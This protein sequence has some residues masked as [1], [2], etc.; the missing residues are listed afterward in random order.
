MQ[1]VRSVHPPLPADTIVRVSLLLE[2]GHEHT[3]W[4]PAR[5]PALAALLT[6]F[7][8]S[9]NGTTREGLVEITIDGG[10]RS[11]CFDRASLVAVITEPP[12]AMNSVT[13]P[14]EPPPLR[15]VP[16][17]PPR[18]VPESVTQARPLRLQNFLRSEEH[19]GLIRYA[20]AR[21]QDFVST[22]V[23]TDH[24]GY[25]ASSV[26]YEFP[27]FEKLLRAK[28]MAALPE[29]FN[30]FKL[31]SFLPSAIEAQLTAHND[32]HFYHVH[33]D[34]GSPATANRALSYVYYFNRQP[35]GFAGG[36]LRLYDTRVENNFYVRA[37]SFT[38]FEPIDNSIIFFLPYFM[39]EVLPVA[40]PSGA[41]A[42]SRFTINGWLRRG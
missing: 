26:L 25:R 6:M 9:K 8:Q 22:R 13:A 3:V 15:A 4:F 1:E 5:D 38:D 24:E 12:I 11:L 29:L 34:N 36:A 30:H 10:R 20:I 17:V 35:R 19:Q 21:E 40:C 37:S 41:F 16:T 33:N 28:I 39:H 32:G 14:S 2:G 23:D 7:I 31:P 27:E 18:A 42:D